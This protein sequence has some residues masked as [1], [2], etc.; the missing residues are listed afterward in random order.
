[1]WFVDPGFFMWSLEIA[2]VRVPK[3]DFPAYDV[4]VHS[5]CMF[6]KRVLAAVPTQWFKASPGSQNRLPKHMTD[7]PGTMTM[8][9]WRH[10]L[11]VEPTCHGWLPSEAASCSGGTPTDASHLHFS[12]AIAQPKITLPKPSSMQVTCDR[13]RGADIFPQ[14]QR[15]PCR[16][17]S[18]FQ[19][20]FRIR[21][22]C[23]CTRT[24]RIWMFSA[25]PSASSQ[26]TS[27]HSQADL[28][29][30]IYHYSIPKLLQPRPP[31]QESV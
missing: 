20:T 31:E 29:H 11:G 6:G 7:H 3:Y 25:A 5:L 24:C 12:R 9:G 17:L 27:A 13:L 28:I 26:R 10:G 14:L 18:H 1:M 21:R 23:L 19:I 4:R 30:S 2:K 22:A 15:F 8:R 16:F